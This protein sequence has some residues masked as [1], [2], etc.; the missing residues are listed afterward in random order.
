MT[1]LTTV[2]ITT[3]NYGHF[4]KYAIESVL[5]QDF[6]KE[7]IEI[8]IIDDGSTD[9]TKDI[10]QQYKNKL[11]YIYQEN[12]G[13]GAAIN[14]GLLNSKGKYIFLLDADDIFYPDKIKETIN[15]FKKNE[16]IGMVRHLLDTMDK[17]GKI[18]P[19]TNNLN[20]PYQDDNI[21]W[22]LTNSIYKTIG[23]S[24]LAYRRTHLKNLLPI[25]S[26]LKICPDEY[27]SNHIIFYSKIVTLNK[28][29]G[30]HRLHG[31]N[32]FNS[33]IFSKKKII[34][35]INIR[36]KLDYYLQM[37]LKHLG[38]DFKN[39]IFYHSNLFTK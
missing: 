35:F 23:T 38:L 13:Q 18:T 7:Q 24:G 36:R 10:V 25:P 16:T 8:I 34:S 19:R 9:K 22:I 12:Q 5:E 15:T 11:K 27:L 6:P 26:D 32:Y 4:I 30:A 29:L 39:D 37:R 2:L 20:F 28:H 31:K 3:Y 33:N 14:N 17:K 1:Q 21:E